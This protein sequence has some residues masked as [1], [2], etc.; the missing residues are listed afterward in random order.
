MRI[1]FRERETGFSLIEL[2]VGIAIVAILAALLLPAL[3]AA[4]KRARRLGCL[5]NLKQ[6]Q[7]AWLSYAHDS[8]DRLCPIAWVPGDMNSPEDAT[9][10]A[11]L[12][13]G[14][15]YAYCKSTKV[16]KCPAD[17]RPNSKS[18]VVTVRSYSINTYLNGFDISAD[19][20]EVDGEYRVETRLSQIASPAPARRIVF[21]DES[22][23]SLD[24]CNF[25]LLP[26]MLGTD[27]AEV[28]HWYNYPAARHSNGAAFSFAD[29][30]VAAIQW[31]GPLLKALE[32]EGPPGNYTTELTG[33]DLNDLRQ[34]QD[35]MALPAGRN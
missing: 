20:A 15:L 13:E 21:V 31:R 10:T 5:N 2:L 17:V 27:H 6:L 19:L 23:N 24:D 30:H 8:D 33:A 18:Q 3:S 14:P 1:R 35:G 16:C 34:V 26:S 29:G 11:L 25:G 9:N 12:E 32:A 22:Q 7:T 4:Q 28:D